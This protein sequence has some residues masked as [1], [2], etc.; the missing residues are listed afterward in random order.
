MPFKTLNHSCCDRYKGVSVLTYLW[1]NFPAADFFVV[2]DDDTCAHL[3]PR[4]APAQCILH[5]SSLARIAFLCSETGRGAVVLLSCCQVCNRC[6]TLLPQAVIYAFW[7]GCLTAS[8]SL[9]SHVSY[10]LSPQLRAEF[11]FACIVAVIGFFLSFSALLMAGHLTMSS[12]PASN[13]MWGTSET[14]RTGELLSMRS[15]W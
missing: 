9:I 13:I 11:D 14:L 2:L 1:E 6:D 12:S 4:Q 3:R 5:H 7:R 10:L 8:S 15:L